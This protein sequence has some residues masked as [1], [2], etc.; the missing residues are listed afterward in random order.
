MQSQIQTLT[1]TQ[2][3]FKELE[4]VSLEKEDE[5]AQLRKDLIGALRNQAVGA[6]TAPKAEPVDPYQKWKESE[7]KN[8]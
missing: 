8:G 6:E 7:F 2:T 1:E 5:I 3:K 4:K